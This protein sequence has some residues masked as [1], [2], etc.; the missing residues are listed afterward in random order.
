[1]YTFKTQLDAQE[2]DTFVINSPLTNLLQSAHWSTVKDNWNNERVGFYKD[3]ELVAVA[4]ILIRP[5]PLGFSMFYIPR[6]PIMDYDN[7]DLVTF[8]LSSLKAIAK[9]H[10]AILITFDP[11]LLIRQYQLGEISEDNPDT[12]RQLK[13]LQDA[14][15]IWSG[16]TTDLSATIQPRFQA[17]I[18][19]EQFGMEL[20]SKKIRQEIRTAQNK[21]LTVDVGKLDLL[22]QFSKLMSKTAERKHINLRNED[23]YRTLLT[24][25][26]DNAHIVLTSLNLVQQEKTLT[27]RLDQATKQ[28]E[29][30][31]PKTAQG[32]I[33]EVQQS[34]ERLTKELQFIREELAKGSQKIP[35]AATLTIDFGKTSENLY[36]GMDE[37]FRH[38]QPAVLTW[39]QTALKAFER[40]AKRHNMGGVENQLEGGLI[41]FKSKFNPMIEEYIGEFELPVYKPLYKLAK[42]ALNLRQKLR[43]KH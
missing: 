31:T 22:P 36:A 41:Q 35:L 12:L 6:G 13:L 15:A 21:G 26:P 10:R 7:P 33:K 11:S 25:Y 17:N 39:Y 2:H 32:K 37:K 9:K 38:Y 24:T 28:T 14:G 40:G 19:K 42:L 4:S 20:L 16:R 5:L 3:N 30:F 8:V 27:N 23:Y 34:I 18:H 43:R 29:Q 1:M